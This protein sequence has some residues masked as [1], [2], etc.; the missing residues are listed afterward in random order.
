MRVMAKGIGLSREEQIKDLVGPA[1]ATIGADLHSD[2]LR[3][4]I[5]LRLHLDEVAEVEAA[6]LRNDSSRSPSRHNLRQ[7]ANRI[8]DSRRTRSKVFEHQIFGEPAWDMLLALYFMPAKGEF[9]TVTAL[10]YAADVPVS[11][12]L[13]WQATLTQE[14]LI[15][16]GPQGVD[17]RKQFVRLTSEGRILMDAYL[18]RLY[19]CEVVADAS[20]CL[21]ARVVATSVK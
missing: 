11:T 21:G 6:R 15:E 19:F 14:G 1:E 18:T 7:I 3:L 13:R 17:K 9:L 10:C 12:G 20:A 16:R 4:Q 2:D 8:Y 5:N